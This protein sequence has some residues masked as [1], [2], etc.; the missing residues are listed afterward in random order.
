M[1]L[2]CCVTAID[3]LVRRGATINKKDCSAL[4]NSVLHYVA[5]YGTIDAIK[6]LVF[7]GADLTALN[8]VRALR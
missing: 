8:H 1:D 6:R 7:H 2:S 4:P 5:R 3:E